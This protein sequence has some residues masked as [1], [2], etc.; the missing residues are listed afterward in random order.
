MTS[1]HSTVSEAA[2]SA[3][4]GEPDTRWCVRRHLRFGWWSL[5]LFVALGATLESLHGFKVG[6]YLNSSNETRRLLWTLAHAHG[7][8]LGLLNIGFAATVSLL[9]EWTA[10]SLRIASGSLLASTALLPAG[11]FLGGVYIHDGD[12]GLAITLVPPGALLLL[13][14][15]VLAARAIDNAKK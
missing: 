6:M 12:P 2:D 7:T 8:L 9:P 3:V 5:A 13:V 11:F 1:S 14:A 4:A 10:G 15:V